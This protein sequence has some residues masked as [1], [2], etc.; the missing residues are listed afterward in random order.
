MVGSMSAQ[1]K[2]TTSGAILRAEQH[3]L[4]SIRTRKG[5]YLLGAVDTS[6]LANPQIF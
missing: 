4:K 2:P 1:L 3:N 6:E 5:D